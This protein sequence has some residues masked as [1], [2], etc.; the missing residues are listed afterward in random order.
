MMKVMVSLPLTVVLSLLLVVVIQGKSSVEGAI[1]PYV[2]RFKDIQRTGDRTDFF[3]AGFLIG[4][5]HPILG[6][7]SDSFAWQFEREIESPTGSFTGRFVLPLHGSAHNV[8][9]QTF[10][11][12]G[13]CGLLTLLAI[14][15]AMLV[16]VPRVLRNA[17]RSIS[18]KLIVLTAGCYASA[19]L[20]YG[21]V[22][23]VF[24]VQVLQFLF[25]I[26]VGLV[27][28]VGY[29]GREISARTIRG[30]SWLC[31][32]LVSLHLTWEF[33][34]PG[35]TRKFYGENRQFG[36]FP[37]ES[38]P[39]GAPYRWCGE[40]ATIERSVD[41]MVSSVDIVLEAGPISQTIKLH[42]EGMAAVY[43]SLIAGEKRVVTVSLSE[44]SQA[45]GRGVIRLEASGSFVPKLLWPSTEDTRRL[46]FKLLGSNGR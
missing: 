15:L 25:F 35:H 30:A 39:V 17:N 27:A 5:L 9:A 2:S 16:A 7:G 31:F 41:P 45:R 40:R 21:N 14:P 1:S 6:G 26:L 11:G 38:P 22:Q 34:I 46:A 4:S 36:C 29:Q 18:D 42:D 3:K 12:K 33:G 28:A 37:Q 43:V 20:I 32:A 44:A 8:Y 23:E 13:L 10:S 19:F 24:Y